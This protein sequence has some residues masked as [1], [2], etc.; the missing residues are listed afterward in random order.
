MPES[1]EV[2]ALEAIPAAAYRRNDSPPSVPF[3]AES[4]DRAIVSFSFAALLVGDDG[5]P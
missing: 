5:H 2:P 4:D 3:S 1:Q